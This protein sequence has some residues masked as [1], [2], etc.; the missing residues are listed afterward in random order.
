MTVAVTLKE[1]VRVY[2][3]YV[4]KA[5]VSYLKAKYTIIL[6]F[7]NIMTVAHLLK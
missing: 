4:D 7:K 5:L 1:G 6:G 2:G 3:T